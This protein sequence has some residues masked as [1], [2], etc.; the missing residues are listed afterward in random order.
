MTRASFQAP[1]QGIP[2]HIYNLPAPSVSPRLVYLSQPPHLALYPADAER[3]ASEAVGPAGLVAHAGSVGGAA[4]CL[5]QIVPS[6]PARVS[7]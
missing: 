7:D 6:H 5:H 1:L 2:H 4:D 3:G